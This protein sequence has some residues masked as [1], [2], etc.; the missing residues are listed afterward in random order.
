MMQFIKNLWGFGK[1][2]KQNKPETYED[3]VENYSPMDG[4]SSSHNTFTE[5]MS[6][7]KNLFKKKIESQDDEDTNTI[8]PLSELTTLDQRA[9]N[10]R[11]KTLKRA[12]LTVVLLSFGM[13]MIVVLYKTGVILYRDSQRQ[14][15]PTKV[16]NLKLEINSMSKWQELKDQQIHE[17]GETIKDVN[18]SVDKKITEFHSSIT[19][20]LDA[21]NKSIN[22][23]FKI[24]QQS[25]KEA[26]NETLNEIKNEIH[27][28]TSESKHYTDQKNLT[29]T[30]K[31]A[32]IESKKAKEPSLDFSKAQLPQ[33]AQPQTQPQQS[34][35]SSG[36]NSDTPQIVSQKEKAIQMIEEDMGTGGTLDYATTIVKE[37]NVTD[38]LP[39]MTLMAGFQ[40]ATL[41]TG[42]DVPTLQKGNDLTRTVWFST[43]GD[44]LIANGHTENIKECIIQA[45]ATGNFASASADIR[46]TKISCSAMDENGKYYKLV[47]NV[48][49]WVYGENGKQGLKGRLVT[50]EGE[51]IEKA[52]PLALLEGAIKALENS[53]KSNSTIY[54]YPGSSTGTSTMNNIQDSFTEG[55]TKTASTTL[56]KF[57]DYYLMILEQLNPTIELKAGRE[58][59]IGFEGGEVLQLEE[60]TPADV[61]FF[62]KRGF[63]Q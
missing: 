45:A 8:D 41:I 46:L 2:F 47:G 63:L 35:V 32:Q 30:E 1:K 58:T 62:E 13:F 59:T 9:D 24:L 52:I 19:Q 4:L 33:V 14:E 40:R 48:K 60:Y 5:S 15:V 17:L 34:S 12:I 22:E 25:N 38:K 57:S 50:K 53:T 16:Q 28:A 6:N 37:D 7:W 27:S 56:D 11:K 61:D 49:G 51:L 43:T 23:S 39:K 36:L 31:I 54:T 26:L 42:A 21:N 3:N 18:Q 55:T 44:M 20:E 10:L 29:I